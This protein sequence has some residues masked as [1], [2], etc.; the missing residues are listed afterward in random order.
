MKLPDQL[1]SDV[2]F[3]VA[4]SLFVAPEEVA[5]ADVVTVREE[6]VRETG[7]LFDDCC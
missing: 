4:S 6:T 2:Y 5:R 7:D 1:K 3:R